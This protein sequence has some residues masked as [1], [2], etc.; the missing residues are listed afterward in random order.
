MTRSKSRTRILN[1][2]GFKNYE[3][4]ACLPMQFR[5]QR[6][7]YKLFFSYFFFYK[8]SNC[9]TLHSDSEKTNEY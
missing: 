3:I 2:V 8:N 7:I 5:L 6:V 9:G 4:K 1:Q